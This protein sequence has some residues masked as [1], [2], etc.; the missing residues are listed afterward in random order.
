MRSKKGEKEKC[1][2]G[3]TKWKSIEKKTHNKRKNNEKKKNV[4]IG[5]GALINDVLNLFKG[6]H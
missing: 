4:F 3:N 6:N 2:V 1:S 5:G